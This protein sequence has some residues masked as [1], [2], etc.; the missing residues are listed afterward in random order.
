LEEQCGGDEVPVDCSC[1]MEAKLQ[2]FGD[3]ETY[4]FSHKRESIGGLDCELD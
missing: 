4:V 3:V 2:H 1:W